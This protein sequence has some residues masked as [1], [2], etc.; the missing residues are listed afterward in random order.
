MSEPGDA[1]AFE[2]LHVALTPELSISGMWLPGDGKLTVLFLHD[3]GADLDAV[4]PLVAG[5]RL[6]EA[7]KVAIDLP[8]H[9]L[10]GGQS[11]EAPQSLS[12]LCDALGAEGRGPF[13]IVGCGY[14]ARLAWTLGSRRDVL[15]LVL[16]SPV[17]DDA[18][19]LTPEP[20]RRA[21]VLVFLAAQSPEV[22][23]AWAKLKTR[24][25]ARWLSASLA[26]THDDLIALRDCDRQVASHIGG[27]ARDLMSNASGPL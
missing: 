3:H 21:P 6:P 12:M 16:I 22:V 10:S 11:E 17:L 18:V 27:F 8:G 25:R 4:L 26:V 23:S 1:V 14:A 19:P 9:G 5:L 24:L 13:V 2:P 15:G 7:H 20:F